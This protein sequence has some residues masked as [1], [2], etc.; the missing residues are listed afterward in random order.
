[1]KV[2]EEHL[3]TETSEERKVDGRRRNIWKEEK[4]ERPTKSCFCP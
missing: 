1:M 3:M 2:Q 4:K